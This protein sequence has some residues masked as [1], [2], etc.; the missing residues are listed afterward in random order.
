MKFIIKITATLFSLVLLGA[1]VAGAYYL[2]KHVMDL[3]ARLDVQIHPVA[4][5]ASLVILLSALAVA[6]GIREARKR[7]S[8]QRLVRDKA[9][10][11][12]RIVHEWVAAD[13]GR[14]G[15]IELPDAVPDL[16]RSLALRAGPAVLKAYAALKK[17]QENSGSAGPELRSQLVYVLF[18]MRKDLG[19][20]NRGLKSGELPGLTAVRSDVRPSQ[21]GIT[22]GEDV[23][24]S[25]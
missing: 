5:L 23:A 19:L 4:E 6:G 24:I 2:F 1:I 9:A 20:S 17:I 12:E 11:Y 16:E 3:Y 7:K 22:A 25:V 21:A 10:L 13:G 15:D 8:D 18:Q 14:S